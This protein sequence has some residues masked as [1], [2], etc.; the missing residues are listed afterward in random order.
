MIAQL[1]EQKAPAI[2]DFRIIIAEL[3]PMVAQGQW[4]IEIVGQWLEPSEMR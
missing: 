3:M 1:R 4:R 2:A